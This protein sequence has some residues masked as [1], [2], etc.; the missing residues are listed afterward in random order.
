LASWIS[1]EAPF[2]GR[3]RIRLPRAPASL[4]QSAAWAGRPCRAWFRRRRTPPKTG[5]VVPWF[6]WPALCAAVGEAAGEA[7][8]GDALPSS[9]GDTRSTVA[10]GHIWAWS[11]KRG[12]K[13]DGVIAGS[14]CSDLDFSRVSQKGLDLTVSFRAEAVS[15]DGPSAPMDEL[16]FG[17]DDSGLASPSCSWGGRAVPTGRE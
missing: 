8:L 14:L 11:L 2:S 12:V 16:P 9:R 1:L 17:D 10:P 6:R 13:P 7:A 15:C 3:A 5:A 4:G